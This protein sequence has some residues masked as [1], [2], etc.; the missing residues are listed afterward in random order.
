ML[1]VVG[2]DSPAALVG[3]APDHPIHQAERRLRRWIS[4]ARARRIAFRCR[5]PSSNG[6]CWGGGDGRGCSGAVAVANEPP[7][8]SKSRTVL[9]SAVICQPELSRTTSF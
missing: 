2:G 5:F 6:A 9:P 4:R 7:L 3:A 8:S 1:D